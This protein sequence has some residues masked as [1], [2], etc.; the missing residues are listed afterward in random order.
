MPAAPA[1]PSRDIPDA[2]CLPGRALAYRDAT[3][4]EDE[5]SG[6]VEPVYEAAQ[7]T[8]ST[9]GAIF[10]MIGNPTRLQG[11]FYNTHH[12]SCRETELS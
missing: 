10:I 12:N 2:P 6:V 1:V 3:G 9:P 5:A 4:R 7:G 11:F 8:L